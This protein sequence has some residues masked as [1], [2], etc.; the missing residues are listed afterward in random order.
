VPQDQP[1]AQNFRVRKNG[2]LE[3][4][5]INVALESFVQGGDGSLPHVRSHSSRDREKNR[6]SDQKQSK[7]D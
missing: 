1:G 4:R 7:N 2:D 5:Q 3:R 6:T